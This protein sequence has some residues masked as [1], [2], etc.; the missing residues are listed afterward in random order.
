M[1]T[2][3]LNLPSYKY[4]LEQ[5]ELALKAQPDDS[6]L[7][8]LKQDLEEVINLTAELLGCDPSLNLEDSSNIDAYSTSAASLLQQPSTTNSLTSSARLP[9]KWKTGDRCLAAWNEDGKY[10]ECTIDDVLDDGTCTIVYDGFGTAEVT[11]VSKLKPFDRTRTTMSGPKSSAHILKTKRELETRLREL[12]RK[13]Q[14]KKLQKFKELEEEREKDKKRWVD[15][16]HKLTGR[17][18]KGVVSK[19]M[20]KKSEPAKVNV[21]GV[22]GSFMTNPSP[23]LVNRSHQQQ[24]ALSTQT[25]KCLQQYRLSPAQQQIRF[26]SS[27]SLPTHTKL[28]LPALSP[29]METGTIR[30]WS[31]QEGDKIVEGDLIGEIETDKT[32]LGF[33]VGEEGYLAKILLPAGSKDVPVGTVCAIVVEKQEDVAAFKDYKDDGG[34]TATSSTSEDSSKKK[35]AKAP[36][37]KKETPKKEDQKEQEKS[38]SDKKAAKSGETETKQQQTKKDDKDHV[39]ISPFAKKLANEK[40]IDIQSIQGSGPNGRIVAEDVEKF[41]KE[42]G[43]KQQQAKP[44]TTAKGQQSAAKE[45]KDKTA[46]TAGGYDETAI[47]EIRAATA[48]RVTQ[49]KTTIP[50]YYLTIEIEMDQIIKLRQ[51]LND[52]LQSKDKKAKGITINDFI[53][54]AAALACKK[55]PETNSV[56]MDKTIRQYETVDINVA[57]ATDAG[58]MTPIIYN[59]DQKGLSQISSDI[60]QLSE[61][62]SSGKLSADEL[63]S[64]TFTIANLGMYGINNFSAVIYPQQS[65]ILAIGGAETRLVPDQKNEK[66]YRSSTV[67]NITLSCDH[68][69]VDGAVGAHWLQE[70]KSFL[71]N[72]GSMIL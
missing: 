10:Y 43:T 68:R 65:C 66:G 8:R 72:P 39:F 35:E 46:A 23:F 24:R 18:W 28:T 6:E 1:D 12:K 62:A 69:V 38:P 20:V 44:A 50:H 58:L 15:F 16:N 31:K 9:I 55:V 5:V 57:I 52:M 67:V 4:Q 64:G 3:D 47:S 41:I 32:T 13:K 34:K 71:E 48:K 42:G 7:L 27:G 53:I 61:K 19:S 11:V 49:S 45:K 30:S 14:Q 25:T 40:G 22:T 51:T 54:K 37:K 56:W 26:A 17:T 33:E 60:A 59:A 2:S 36:E 70:F 21:S 29:T 63:E